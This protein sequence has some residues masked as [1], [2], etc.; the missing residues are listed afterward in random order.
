MQRPVLPPGASGCCGGG[1]SLGFSD[2]PGHPTCPDYPGYEQRCFTTVVVQG[3]PAEQEYARSQG[4]VPQERPCTTTGGNQGSIWCCAPGWPRFP[5]TPLKEGES[6]TPPTPPPPPGI[7]R[8]VRQWW[9]WGV[10]GGFGLAAYFG[11]K[12]YQSDKEARAL[13]AEEPGW[14]GYEEY[15]ED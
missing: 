8:W 9:F 2:I 4:C 3:R 6:E 10:V 5:G 15:G 14:E 1:S 11:W 13:P 12:S 7:Q